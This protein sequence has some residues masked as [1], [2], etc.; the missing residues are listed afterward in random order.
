MGSLAVI[1]AFT[2]S[3]A[4]SGPPNGFAVLT[5]TGAVYT[6]PLTVLNSSGTAYSVNKTVLDSSGTPYIVS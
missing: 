5:S 1:G 3:S 4:G 2:G 6:V